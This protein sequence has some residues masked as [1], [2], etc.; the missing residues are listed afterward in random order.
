VPKKL[1][2]GNRKRFFLSVRQDQGTAKK[3]EVLLS[4][5]IDR[6]TDEDVRVLTLS[7]LKDQGRAPESIRKLSSL[8]KC[9]HK[10]S[11]T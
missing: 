10:K 9:W 2:R 11:Q 5:I 6:A 1:L 4:D 3:I 7:A 8:G